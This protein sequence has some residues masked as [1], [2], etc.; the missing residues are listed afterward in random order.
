VLCIDVLWC[1]LNIAIQGVTVITIIV[2]L[3][4]APRLSTSV[5]LPFIPAYPLPH[6][7]VRVLTC[8]SLVIYPLLCLSCRFKTACFSALGRTEPFWLVFHP[9]SA[10]WLPPPDSF[11]LCCIVSFGRWSYFLFSSGRRCLVFFFLSLVRANLRLS[12][13]GAP[14]GFTSCPSPPFNH[15]LPVRCRLAL[16][17]FPLIEPSRQKHAFSEL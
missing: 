15:T 7:L 17:E 2:R 11:S 8:L 4:V 12:S 3:I 14:V 10:F 5:W 9:R 6:C 16:A 13:A 1:F